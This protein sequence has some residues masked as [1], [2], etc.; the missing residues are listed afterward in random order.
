MED[1]DLN[2][3][4][5]NSEGAQVPTAKDELWDTVKTILY[6]VLIAIGVRT[7]AYE[8]FNGRPEAGQACVFREAEGGRT[9]GGHG[10]PWVRS[11]DAQEGPETVR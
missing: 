10:V 4:R 2:D 11:P 6:A 8:P 5:L 1:D 7:L 3:I 9:R